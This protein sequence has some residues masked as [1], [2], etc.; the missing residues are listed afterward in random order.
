MTEDLQRR[1]P[2]ERHGGWKSSP[3]RFGLGSFAR[4]ARSPKPPLPT[5]PRGQASSQT[6]RR[7]LEALVALGVIQE[8]PAP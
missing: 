3:T 8:H 4:S 1:S 5:W 7:H 2:L 6:L